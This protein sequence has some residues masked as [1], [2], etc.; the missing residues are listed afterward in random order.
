MKTFFLTICYTLML[1][2]VMVFRGCSSSVE[3]SRNTQNQQLDGASGREPRDPPADPNGTPPPASKVPVEPEEGLPGPLKTLRNKVSKAECEA[4]DS[5]QGEH[6]KEALDLLKCRVDEQLDWLANPLLYADPGTTHSC[7]TQTEELNTNVLTFVG[8]D[9]GGSGEMWLQNACRDATDKALENLG[10]IERYEATKNDKGGGKVPTEASLKRALVKVLTKIKTSKYADFDDDPD[11]QEDSHNIALMLEYSL[12]R[13]NHNCADH[14]D[15]EDFL[16][17]KIEHD[18]SQGNVEV[19]YIF[20]EYI[21]YPAAANKK[22]DPYF[23]RYYNVLVNDITTLKAYAK[24]WSGTSFKAPHKPKTDETPTTYNTKAKIANLSDLALFLNTKGDGALDESDDDDDGYL[25][26]DDK[27][28]PDNSFGDAI[29]HKESRDIIAIRKIDTQC[30]A[31]DAYKRH[32]KSSN[33][34]KNAAQTTFFDHSNFDI[35]VDVNG[36]ACDGDGSQ[37]KVIP[38]GEMCE[39]DEEER[40][41]LVSDF[42]NCRLFRNYS[43]A[44]G[45]TT[46]SSRGIQCH[47]RTKPSGSTLSSYCSALTRNDQPKFVA[48]YC[49]IGSYDKSVYHKKTHGSNIP[50]TPKEGHESSTGCHTTATEDTTENKN[51][52]TKEK[53]GKDACVFTLVLNAATETA[54]TKARG[55]L[56]RFLG[57]KSDDLNKCQLQVDDDLTPHDYRQ[58]DLCSTKYTF[59]TDGGDGDKLSTAQQKKLIARLKKSKAAGADDDDPDPFDVARTKYCSL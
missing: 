40:E 16:P 13:I 2:S 56:A 23:A 57:V 54:R 32:Q 53:K 38:S 55:H 8:K 25:D 33:G 22:I 31:C 24:P 4:A 7:V 45:V 14:M 49:E 3:T 6:I 37:R 21:K 39:A 35:A 36:V 46:E 5:P 29:K 27:V 26:D 43:V 18:E 20:R 28:V 44:S 17:R 10:A 48:S 47:N 41:G 50:P 52:L 59:Y 15:T 30:T 11:S 1:A 12:N 42:A 34:D 51:A 58:Y 9:S 19:S